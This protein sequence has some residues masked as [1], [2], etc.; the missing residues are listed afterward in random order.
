MYLFASTG[1]YYEN[2]NNIELGQVRLAFQAFLPDE[3]GKYNRIV[4][5]SVLSAYLRQK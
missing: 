2:V 1:G 3:S 5:T 4:P